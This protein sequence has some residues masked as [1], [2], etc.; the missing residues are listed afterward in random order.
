MDHDLPTSFESA[1]LVQCTD[2]TGL[3]GR[4]RPAWHAAPGPA[5]TALAEF[6]QPDAAARLA[7]MLTGLGYGVSR[8]VRTGGGRRRYAVH[9]VSVPDA[10]R[11]AATRMMAAAWRRGRHGLFGTDA[12]GSS[13][14]R[15]AER[16]ALARAAWRAALLAGGRRL[17]AGVLWVRLGDQDMAAILVRAA[18]LAGVTAEVTRRPGCLVV[19]VPAA[20]AGLLVGEAAGR[21]HLPRICAKLGVRDR[22][23][24]AAHRPLTRVES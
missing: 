21:T 12:L 9:Q 17:R 24:A 2:V 5:A 14:P 15:H 3:P 8:E 4:R 16:I 7:R 23:A 19:S 20:A 6:S 22:A 11:A 10:E 1:C 18:I 13:S